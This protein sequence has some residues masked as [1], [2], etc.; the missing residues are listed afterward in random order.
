VVAD[1]IAFFNPPIF[2]RAFEYMQI[3]RMET[4]LLL[5]AQWT[6]R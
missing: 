5:N 6:L 3:K 2:L 4:H 1:E